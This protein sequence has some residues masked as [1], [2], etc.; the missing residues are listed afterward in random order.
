MEMLCP[1]PQVTNTRP[2]PPASRP[3]SPF[4]VP[5]KLSGLARMKA[6][7]YGGPEAARY[8]VR[9]TIW[10]DDPQP[11]W[12]D[13]W[14]DG[15]DKTPE[16]KRRRPNNLGV[17]ETRKG[18]NDPVAEEKRQKERDEKMKQLHLDIKD[19]GEALYQTER[20]L[21]AILKEVTAINKERAF[22]DLIGKKTVEQLQF[23]KAGLDKTVQELTDMLELAR[24]FHARV[25]IRPHEQEIEQ[26]QG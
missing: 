20:D 11:N 16:H 22:W 12:R 8:Q 4:P 3:A 23:T 21:E 24:A 17:D 26:S 6:I 18:K 15:P 13:S 14:D 5:T 25:V 2:A 7:A 1:S 19:A 9:D 10:L